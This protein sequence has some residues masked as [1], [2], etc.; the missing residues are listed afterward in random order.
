VDC[1]NGRSQNG[2]SR[3]QPANPVVCRGKV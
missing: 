2:Q 1:S 3:K